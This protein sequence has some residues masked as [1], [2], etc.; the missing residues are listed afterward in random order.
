MDSLITSTE[1]KWILALT[2]PDIK[3]KRNSGGLNVKEK[4]LK[5][6]WDN[7]GE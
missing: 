4:T 5:L 1:E 7:E 3:K 2:L 6:L